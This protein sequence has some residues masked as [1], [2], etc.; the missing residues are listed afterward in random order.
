MGLELTKKGQGTLAR[1]TAYALGA[2]LV[3]YGAIRLYAN[4]PGGFHTVLT[5]GLPI[6]GD[7][8]IR[9]VVAVVVAGLGLLGLHLVLNRPR[10]TDLLIETEGEM[11][12]VTWPTGP[13]VFNA[14]LVVVLVTTVL[15]VAMSAFD[16][17]LQRVLL[18]VF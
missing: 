10:S 18:L 6:V 8:T 3:V 4:L 16:W 9:K 12:K 17:G 1:A 2:A 11:R 7:L 13:E 5:A 14:T 15:A